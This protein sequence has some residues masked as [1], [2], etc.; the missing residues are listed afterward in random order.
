MFPDAMRKYPSNERFN[1]HGLRTLRPWHE[2]RVCGR[3]SGGGILQSLAEA[4]VQIPF[5]SG[6]EVLTDLRRA[7]RG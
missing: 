3:N 7:L 6:R 5:R 2:R 4:P 1:D